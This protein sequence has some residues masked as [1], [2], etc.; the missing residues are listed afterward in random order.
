MKWYNTEVTKLLGINY[1]IIQGPFGGNY[2]SAQLVSVISNLGGMGSFGA[3]SYSP[4]DILDINKSIKN[5]TNKPYALNLWVPLNTNEIH[6][7]T[8]REFEQLKNMFK[9]YFDELQVDMPEMQNTTGHDF[10]KQVE[11]ILESRPVVFSFIFGVPSKEI[12]EACKKRGIKTIGTATTVDEAL[13][14]EEA[15]VNLIVATG[16]EAGGH[17]P[18]FLKSSEDSLTG[19]LSLVPQIRDKVNVPVIA[20]GGIADG[21]GIVAALALGASAVQIGTAFLACQESNAPKD[22]KE[23]LFS[24]LSRYSTLSRVFT[25]RLARALQNKLSEA[26]KEHQSKMAPFPIQSN[27]LGDLKRRATELGRNDLLTFYAGQSAPILKHQK[28]E[29]LFHALI[30]QSENICKQF[31]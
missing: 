28:A 26:F 18:S 10:E 15:G 3:H 14:L 29:E 17:R 11:A 4:E 8:E 7:Y 20:A 30:W 2:S 9:P 25:G 19:T 12:L 16:F 21:R 23:A 31:V 13:L 1:P 6:K 5:L 27:F 22:H 24:N